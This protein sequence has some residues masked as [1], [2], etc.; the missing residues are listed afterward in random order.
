MIGALLAKNPLASG[1][2]IVA[3]LAIAGA[4]VQS[5]RL[6]WSQA[7]THQE[8][9]KFADFKTDLATAALEAERKAK[10]KS[11]ESIK[12]LADEMRSVG[13]VATT[14]KTE[15]RLVQSNGGPCDRDP[16]YLAGIDGVQRILAAAGGAGDGADKAR[17]GAAEKVRAAPG[18]VAR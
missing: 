1:L 18:A 17:P 10:A 14:A 4:G 6:A 7:E 5:L 9:L 15:I 3:A 2:G 11:D 16:A 12:E 8:Q 13:L